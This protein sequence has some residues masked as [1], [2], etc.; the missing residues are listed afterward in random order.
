MTG[1]HA[2]KRRAE[3]EAGRKTRG[4]DAAVSLRRAV[5]RGVLLR[6]ALLSV[7]LTAC[8]EGNPPTAGELLDK[9]AKALDSLMCVVIK[10]E[11]TSEG[12]Y[13]FDRDWQDPLVRG[14]RFRGKT[15]NRSEF[16][17]DGKSLHSRDYDWGNISPDRLSVP[18]HQPSYRCH[19]W[20]AGE[21][22]QHRREVNVPDR[23][24]VV[25]LHKPDIGFGFSRNGPLSYLMGYNLESD[26]RLDS[27]LRRT[28]SIAV[29]PKTQRIG[30]SD[31]WVIDAKT[32]SGR[33][34]VWLDPAHGYHPACAEAE[35]APGDLAYGRP[36][37]KGWA[38][39]T[40]LEN[41]RFE[42]IE[43]L[44]VPME[45]EVTQS[46][47][48]GGNNRSLQKYHHKRTMVLVN[49]DHDALGSF[50]N[51]LRNP[52]NDPELTNGTDVM[53]DN[54]TYHWRDGNVVDEAGSII[55]EG[56]RKE[57]SPRKGRSQSAGAA[58]SRKPPTQQKQPNLWQLIRKSIAKQAPSDPR[59]SAATQ[60]TLPTARELLDKYTR[61]LDSVK[62][63]IV[64][65]EVTNRHEYSF[66]K[67]Y[68]E[69]AFR[70]AR[71]RGV[72][73]QRTE[74]RTDG[75]R[76]HSRQYRWGHLNAADP[77][78]PKEAAAY[79]CL[80]Y[81]GTELYQNTATLKA[82]SHGRVRLHDS[83]EFR[84]RGVD[85]QL[86]GYSIQS[87]ERLD[88]ILRRAKSIAVR[89]KAEKVAG[90]ECYVID[91]N[92]DTG[93]ISAWI[94]PSHG[95]HLA[96]VQAAAKEGDLYW[97]RPL[98]PGW[99]VAN[100]IDGVRFE[101]MNGLW[102]PAE[103]DMAMVNQYGPGSFSRQQTHYRRTHILV[104][105]D[106]DALGSFDNPL[107]NPNNDPQLKNGARVYLHDGRKRYVF[108]NGRLTPDQQRPNA[109]PTSRR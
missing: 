17:T 14:T 32:D 94:D 4:A 23:P 90:S 27:I 83:P 8:A 43:G 45:A 66:G 79:N 78:V 71:D 11:T 108:A 42:R 88:K 9:Y 72:G 20:D 1:S 100:R 13:A 19:N 76:L 106:H 99:V 33:I 40:R 24:G 12:G 70:G 51:P 34:T 57:Y 58:S 10:A 98:R 60:S 29:R 30:G 84:M 38:R 7:C 102:I 81:V 91:A 15:F 85:K 87:D 105:P 103:A 18:A 68:H 46:R 93:R 95:W 25:L 86:M 16:R 44:W 37:S 54:K 48:Y 53:L 61:A 55:I 56:R 64:K 2:I 77:A 96:K 104:N 5:P 67:D 6:A 47:L 22:Y 107:E 82:A 80:N 35:L 28:E 3:S 63:V 109:N 31:C 97:G 49:P 69:P 21:H 50:D 59:D 52:A 65:A 75:R 73:Y 36:L 26:E 92:T 101:K 89:E 74:F 41:V 39:R 62:S